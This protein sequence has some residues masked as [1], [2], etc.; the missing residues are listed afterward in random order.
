M[1]LSK[2]EWDALATIQQ[3]L[4]IDDPRLA[5]KMRRMAVGPLADP[6]DSAWWTV[7]SMLVGLSMIAL[8]ATLGLPALA[9]PGLVIAVGAP[10]VITAVV[11]RRGHR[12]RRA[13]RWRPR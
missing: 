3:T 2:D 12:L 8:G 4:E 7:A 11:V 6:V 9:A 1:T 5:R 10:V 13:R